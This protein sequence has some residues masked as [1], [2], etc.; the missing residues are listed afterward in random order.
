MR[1]RGNIQAAR[2]VGTDAWQLLQLLP[3]VLCPSDNTVEGST[4]LMAE[5]EQELVLHALQII[6]IF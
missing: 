1:Q 2:G 4:Q 6:G 5:G 3:E